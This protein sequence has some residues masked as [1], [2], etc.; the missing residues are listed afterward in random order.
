MPNL[1]LITPRFTKDVD[2]LRTWGCKSKPGDCPEGVN[3]VL[4]E[5]FNRV[6]PG[7]F[8]SILSDNA[9]KDMMAEEDAK[10]I[11]TVENICQKP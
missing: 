3:I 2:E 7:D 10:F 1:K 9:I 6:L 8:R 4:W 5:A 11:Q